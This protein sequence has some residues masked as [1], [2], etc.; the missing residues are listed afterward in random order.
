MALK[1]DYARKDADSLK[2]QIIA[3]LE[4]TGKFYNLTEDSTLSYI[5]E[6]IAEVAS[7]LTYLIDRRAEE[8]YLPTARLLSSVMTIARMLGYFP[9]RKVSSRVKLKFYQVDGDGN[10][11]PATDNIVIPKFTKVLTDEGIQF[12]TTTQA[13]LNAGQEYIYIDAMQGIVHTQT[14]TSNGNP[15]QIFNMELPNPE[16]YFVECK[17]NGEYWEVKKSLIYSNPNDHHVQ[18]DTISGYTGLYF[19]FGDGINGEIPI[20]DAIIEFYAVESLGADGNIYLEDVIKNLI[21]PDGGWKNVNGD[22]LDIQIKCTNIREHPNDP[23]DYAVGGT[24]EEDIEEIRK[25]APRLFKIGEH[26]LTTR[27][28]WIDYISS[29]PG[30]ASCNV[31]SEYEESP[32]NP[33]VYLANTIKI[34]ILMENYAPLTDALKNTILTNL[35]KLKEINTF[36]QIVD[37]N[38]VNV[39][40]NVNVVLDSSYD[41]NESKTTIFNKLAQYI[42]PKD[43]SPGTN[44]YHSKVI[45]YL[46]SIQG[47]NI[48]YVD[49][50]IKDIFIKY[51]P[52]TQKGVVLYPTFKQFLSL[53][54]IKPGSIN[55]KIELDGGSLVSYAYDNGNGRILKVGDNSDIGSID[56]NLGLLEFSNSYNNS[57]KVL[58]YYKQ[59]SIDVILR[60]NMQVI[61]FYSE[62]S[63]ITTSH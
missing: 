19:R 38:F 61:Y 4:N 17:V 37:F 2:Q 23:P 35:L 34:A 10:P 20:K 15:I 36:V 63:N 54:N 39:I 30:V 44:L 3:Y 47:V 53:K 13:V 25:N 14:F 56:Y 50:T 18:C 29:Y 27:Q 11:I 60:N 26:T 58:V 32:D 45:A 31:W 28:D 12:I 51:D 43:F 40:F 62:E 59:D 24:N 42:N 57:N 16:E 6:V 1:L 55:I 7:W 5:V 41:L 52:Q 22:I 48:C 8:C 46:K 21:P 33:N 9:R 49:F